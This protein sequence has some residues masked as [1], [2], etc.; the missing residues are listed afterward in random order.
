MSN[1]LDKQSLSV[2]R[3][4]NPIP[5]RTKIAC[6]NSGFDVES[7]FVEV[8]KIVE[9]QVLQQRK[10]TIISLHVMPATL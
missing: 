8:N 4:T 5:L 2:C 3:V 6:E 10:S 9:K 7:D 1:T